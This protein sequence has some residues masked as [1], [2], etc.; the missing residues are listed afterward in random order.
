MV[1]KTVPEPPD[2]CSH[3]YFFCLFMSIYEYEHENWKEIVW[4]GATSTDETFYA[5]RYSALL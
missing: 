3:G 5:R 2:T 4:L 1:R